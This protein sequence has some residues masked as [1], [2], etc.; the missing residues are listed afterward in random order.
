MFESALT[1]FREV[2]L[3]KQ[4]MLLILA[5][6]IVSVLW[7]I[8]FGLLQWLVPIAIFAMFCLVVY[9]VFKM[10]SREKIM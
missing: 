2:I 8:L 5:I 4:V 9:K 10:L 7:N 3:M 6:I 1:E